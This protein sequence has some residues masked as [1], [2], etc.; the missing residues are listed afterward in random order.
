VRKTE[1]VTNQRLLPL[2]PGD[3]EDDWIAVS[4]NSKAWEVVQPFGNSLWLAVSG[5]GCITVGSVNRLTEIK[6]REDD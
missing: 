3:V 6:S 5:L 1:K 2:P 4:I